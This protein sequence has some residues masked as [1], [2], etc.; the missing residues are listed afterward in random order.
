MSAAR[1]DWSNSKPARL[2][3]RSA[4]PALWL[5]LVVGLTGAAQLVPPQSHVPPQ[6]LGQPIGGGISD[7]PGGNFEQEEEQLRIMNKERQKSLV[8]DTN[9]LLKLAGELD[10][11]LKSTNPDSLTPGQLRKL[12][13]IEKL[14][15]NVKDKMSYSVRT[16]PEFHQPEGPVMR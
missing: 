6:P 12:A 10:A 11:E 2:V 8:S 7:S 1:I 15:H 14:A 13:D 9:R 4:G 5:A 3:R 16:G